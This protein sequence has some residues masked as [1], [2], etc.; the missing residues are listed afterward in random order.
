[1]IPT[2]VP[3]IMTLG[4]MTL[5]GFRYPPIEPLFGFF[6]YEAWKPFFETRSEAQKRI[7]DAFNAYLEK[8][9]D[10]VKEDLAKKGYKRA[11]TKRARGKGADEHFRWLVQYQVLG[12]SMG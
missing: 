7:T 4:L 3:K 1:M 6:V 5:R 2:E 9:M 8:Q 10:S 11:P 12:K